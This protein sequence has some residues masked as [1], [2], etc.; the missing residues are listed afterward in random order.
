[1]TVLPKISKAIQKKHTGEAVAIVDGKIVAY[2]E[3][4]YEAA[5][6][7][8]K[9]GYKQEEIMTTYIMGTKVYAL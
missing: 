2:G 4:S 6:N 7:A 9:K 8:M 3:D 1:M 5:K